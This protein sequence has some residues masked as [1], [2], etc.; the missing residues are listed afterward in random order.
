M[1]K[2]PNFTSR[3]VELA[4]DDYL[5]IQPVAHALSTELRL[6]IVHL[7]GSR[8][9]SVHEIAKALDLPVSTAAM[10]IQV[11]ERAGVLIC[12]TQPGIHGTLKLCRRRVDSFRIGL[13]GAEGR[14]SSQTYELPVGCYSLAGQI[15][16]TCGLARR[17][18][19]LGLDDRPAA[20]HDPA[21]FSASLLWLG[22]GF[23][24]YHFPR[25]ELPPERLES[26]DFSFEACSEAS[27]YRNDWPSDIQVEVNGVPLGAWRCPGDFGG[28][29]GLLNPPWWN[30]GSTQYGQLKT[31]RVDHRGTLLDSRY[32]S[33]VTLADLEL[34]RWEYTSLRISA[35]YPGGLNLFGKDFGDYAQGI[36]M[37][38]TGR[39]HPG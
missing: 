28:R 22:A 11:L 13:A 6:R 37:T 31:W 20:F 9:M 19:P 33:A 38:C 15:R 7:L 4:I 5:S 2:V 23:V 32:I 18:G 14:L 36:R 27:G 12:E 10:N 34:A 8:G 30:D 29:R 16:P 17:E 3:E 24:T 1:P 21:H 25:V 35:Q 26:L 39:K